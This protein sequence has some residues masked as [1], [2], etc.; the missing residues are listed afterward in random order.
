MDTNI[1]RKRLRLTMILL[2]LAKS[3][4]Y[5]DMNRA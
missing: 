4:H 2:D 3:K 5:F 1:D